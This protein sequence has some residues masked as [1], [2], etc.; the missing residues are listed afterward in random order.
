MC[1]AFRHVKVDT[2]SQPEALSQISVPG[3]GPLGAGGRGSLATISRPQACHVGEA[4]VHMGA[5]RRS[6]LKSSPYGLNKEYRATKPDLAYS[7]QTLYPWSAPRGG[8]LT[9]INPTP[10]HFSV[11]ASS[12][13]VHFGARLTPPEALLRS[14]LL[15]PFTSPSCKGQ[16]PFSRHFGQQLSF[17][18]T[19]K[20][21][22]TSPCCGTEEAPP[23]GVPT[24]DL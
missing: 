14:L 6:S 20:R 3:R 24:P 1:K 10:D 2:L 16:Y 17:Q 13:L 8:T 9:P 4:R 15:P 22:C 19:N 18:Y 5:H 7:A 21:T 23:P 11:S 12:C